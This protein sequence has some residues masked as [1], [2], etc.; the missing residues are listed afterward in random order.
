[1]PPAP[2]NDARSASTATSRAAAGTGSG[3]VDRWICY[4]TAGLRESAAPPARPATEQK[5]PPA[6]GPV[7]E[8][9]R[10]YIAAVPQAIGQPTEKAPAPAAGQGGN[11]RSAPG[12]SRRSV[13]S[14]AQRPQDP[15]ASWCRPAWRTWTGA[16][17]KR[18]AA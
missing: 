3:S 15:Q 11:R 7:G 12:Q 14:H 1:M 16:P 2:A 10:G 9:G 18:P 17:P 5:P 13:Q 8:K 6:A 4:A